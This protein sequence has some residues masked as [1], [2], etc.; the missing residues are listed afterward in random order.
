MLVPAYPEAPA[1]YENDHRQ[2]HDESLL[3]HRHV[4][5]SYS[6]VGVAMI[7]MIPAAE[8][9]DRFSDE[10]GD[11]GTLQDWLR[12]IYV[13]RDNHH[14]TDEQVARLIMEACKGRA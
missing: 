14:W 4:A 12:E 7:G 6:N 8:R 10:N 5:T 1:Q 9:I 13:K 2:G 11:C 3:A